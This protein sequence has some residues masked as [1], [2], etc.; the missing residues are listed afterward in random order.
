MWERILYF[1]LVVWLA[2]TFAFLL[3]RAVPGDALTTTLAASGASRADVEQIREDMG[4]NQPLIAQYLRYITGLMRGDMGY[5]LTNTLPVVEM[6]LPRL[7]PTATLA[8]TTLLIAA[9]SGIGLGVASTWQGHFSHTAQLMVNLSLSVPIYWTG[10]LAIMIFSAW[11]RWLPSSGTDGIER[12]VLPVAVL[13]F[14]MMGPIARVT[15]ANLRHI[16]DAPF[17]YTARAKGLPEYLI[18]WRHI[19]RVGL[20]PVTSVI[21]LQ[22]GFLL[23]GTVITESLFVRAGIGQLLLTSAINRDYPVVQGIIVFSAVFY[24]SA[25]FLAEWIARI[26]DPRISA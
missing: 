26:I 20:A 2:A 24:L 17:V 13:S 7:Y 8:F 21:A 18:M 3:L 19:I 14:H 4:L 22:A 6:I 9:L 16:Q 1:I 15:Y 5:S 10:T 23:S 12:L 25:N 11:L